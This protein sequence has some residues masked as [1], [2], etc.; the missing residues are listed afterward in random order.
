M[1][2][3]EECFGG[4]NHTKYGYGVELNSKT[5]ITINARLRF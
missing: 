5:K 4:K 3:Q 2:Y 1:T